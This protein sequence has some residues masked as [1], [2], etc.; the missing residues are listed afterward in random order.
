[1]SALAEAVKNISTR[2]VNTLTFEIH[3]ANTISTRI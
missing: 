1:M 3:V 2:T